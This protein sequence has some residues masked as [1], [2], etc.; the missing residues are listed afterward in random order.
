[1]E[2][3]IEKLKNFLESK[4]HYKSNLS[5]I[6]FFWREFELIKP[7]YLQAY[8][9]EF[10]Y[11][12]KNIINCH[13]YWTKTI[14]GWEIWSQWR[15]RVDFI[16]KDSRNDSKLHKVNIDDFIKMVI[17]SNIILK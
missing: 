11:N 2:N 14:I 13:N 7:W 17:N 9:D 3:E 12:K 8:P 4:E 10:I 15:Y 1:M 5:D 16:T 6:L